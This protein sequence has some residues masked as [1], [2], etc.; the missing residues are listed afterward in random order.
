MEDNVQFN[1]TEEVFPIYQ[2]VA[3]TDLLSILLVLLQVFFVFNVSTAMIILLCAMLILF[4]FVS[5]PKY[6]YEHYPTWYS[7]RTVTLH[8]DTLSIETPEELSACM[9]PRIL[10]SAV[11]NSSISISEYMWFEG[12]INNDS[13]YSCMELY[14][15]QMF[16]HEKRICL[17]HPPTRSC[18][19][20]GGT[21]HQYDEWKRALILKKIP[22]VRNRSSFEPIVVFLMITFGLSLSF[23]SFFSYGILFPFLVFPLVLGAIGSYL[24][25][26]DYFRYNRK[27][28][29]L[30]LITMIVSAII[31]YILSSEK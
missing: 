5:I 7:P 17:Y 23:L 26:N 20:V 15:L 29:L 8:E 27:Y 28:Y 16:Y 6:Y 25:G 12:Y 2:G 3:F 19:A 31:V 21:P 18:I 13:L 10:F 1:I 9:R 22:K 4:M 30:W 24:C 14:Y 11:N